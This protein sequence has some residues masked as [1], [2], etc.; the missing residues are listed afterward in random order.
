M[1][2]YPPA[3]ADMRE[4]R[5]HSA[6]AQV[7]YPVTMKSVPPKTTSPFRLRELYIEVS[8]I[9]LK[10]LLAWIFNLQHQIGIL[11]HSPVS[12]YVGSRR[13]HMDASASG[14]SPMGCF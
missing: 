4:V 7:L 5:T 3:H 13:H 14:S 8:S 12:K 10:L 6:D 9:N 1:G 2:T 11:V